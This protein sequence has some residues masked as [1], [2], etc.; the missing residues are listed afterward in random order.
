MSRRKTTTGSLLALALLAVSSTAHAAAD[1]QLQTLENA[2][3]MFHAASNSV[4]YAEAAQQ[5]EYLVKEEGIRNGKLFYTLGNS[6]FMA[7]DLGRAILNYRRAEQY[8]PNDADVRYNLNTALTQRTDLIPPKP[9]STLAS[10]LLGWH[11]NTSAFLRGWLFATCWLVFWG[12]WFWYRKSRKKETRILLLV[13]GL[14]SLALLASL[15][16][17]QIQKQRTKQGVIVAPEVLARKGDGE[18]YGPAFL[19]PLHSGTEFQRLEERGA[20]WHIRLPDGQTCWIPA[21][22]GEMVAL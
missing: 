15:L 4:Q 7:G 12:A 18:M 2:N 20:W 6:W 14:L 19:D 9:P 21:R 10:T 8:L 22:A 3:A 13:A 17:D 5:Y 11:F 1:Y 16:T